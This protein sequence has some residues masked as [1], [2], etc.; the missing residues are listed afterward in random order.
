MSPTKAAPI[1]ATSPPPLSTA[2]LARFFIYYSKSSRYLCWRFGSRAVCRSSAKTFLLP[3]TRILKCVSRACPAAVW[4]QR[5]CA[6]SARK[7]ICCGQCT[8]RR[9]SNQMLLWT[10]LLLGSRL[11]KC[12][13]LLDLTELVNPLLSMLSRENLLPTRAG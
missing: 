13:P 11:A 7:A 10:M 8:S 1:T 2:T 12:L 9:R 5:F 6:Q 3:R 4:Q